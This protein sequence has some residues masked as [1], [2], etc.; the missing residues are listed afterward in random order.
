MLLLWGCENQVH[1]R[2][3]DSD[4]DTVA[5][6]DVSCDGVPCTATPQ[7]G[8]ICDA[9][10]GCCTCTPGRGYCGNS[11]TAAYVC[12]DNG[13][14]YQEILCPPGTVCAERRGSP[15]CEAPADGDDDDDIDPEDA[16]PDD[17][18]MVD[19]DPDMIDGDDEELPW[20]L[21]IPEQDEEVVSEEDLDDTVDNLDEEELPDGDG[22]EPDSEEGESEEE[23]MYQGLLYGSYRLVGMETVPAARVVLYHESSYVAERS[24][25]NTTEYRFEDLPPGNYRVVIEVPGTLEEALERSDNLGVNELQRL[26][27]AL[28]NP[29]GTVEVTVLLEGQDD[30]HGTD[31]SIP[32][33]SFTAVTNASGVA[34]LQRVPR[35]EVS[36]RMEHN[37]YETLLHSGVEVQYNETTY[38]NF[39]LAYASGPDN[40]IRG[41]ARYFNREDASTI[42]ITLSSQDDFLPDQTTHP[43]ANGFWAFDRLEAGS[44][45][46]SVSADWPYQT[47]SIRD[48]EVSHASDIDTGET[49]LR[50]AILRHSGIVENRLRY[51]PDRNYVL[52][53]TN[54]QGDF[55]RLWSVPVEPVFAPAG[56]LAPSAYANSINFVR[57]TTDLLYLYPYDA[58]TRTATI[59]RADMAMPGTSA[60]VLSDV[61]YSY[62][63]DYSATRLIYFRNFAAATA[64]G[65]V[66]VHYLENGDDYLLGENA[67]QGIYLLSGIGGVL[68]TRLTDPV[69]RAAELHFAPLDGSAGT[70]IAPDVYQY[71]MSFHTD[72]HHM[73]FY[74]VS[75]I[76]NYGTLRSVDLEDLDAPLGTM[77]DN[78][79]VQYTRFNPNGDRVFFWRSVAGSFADLYAVDIDPET[80][81]PLEEPRLVVPGFFRYLHRF[82]N[83]EDR[84]VVFADQQTDG[85]FSC[86][87]I[88]TANGSPT[89]LVAGVSNTVLRASA[90]ERWMFVAANY[91]NGYGDIL[92]I[93]RQSGDVWTVATDV[94][95]SL[96]SIDTYNNR[97]I[98]FRDYDAAEQSGTMFVQPLEPGSVEIMVEPMMYFNYRALPGGDKL[99]VLGEY[100]GGIG[101]LRLVDTI[102]WESTILLDIPLSKDGYRLMGQQ[103]L[104]ASDNALYLLPDFDG[105]EALLVAEKTP[106]GLSTLLVDNAR[107]MLWYEVTDPLAPE[108]VSP[109]LYQLYLP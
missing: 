95:V 20:E 28:F 92:R 24:Q 99:L 74:Q 29:V 76:D 45:D 44:Y 6:Q 34:V 94:Y 13:D 23:I 101:T 78:A 50:Y 3:L 10:C 14:C 100:G 40:R 22:P 51:S 55:V 59:N 15:R 107:R 109:G 4:G 69:Q 31:V 82:L 106:Q 93:D 38:L 26:P 52:F 102:T 84:V 41:N 57:D 90:D 72:G 18:D 19:I 86:L 98:Y 71:T 32:G 91:D 7:C 35:G 46:I 103:M 80:L 21:E 53:N 81:E 63:Y 75:D 97:M 67:N 2:M 36:I 37:G 42:L 66:F 5:E 60:S 87:D 12:S 56:I 105:G 16:E 49:V 48:I 30:H 33:T 27:T 85:S 25:F 11:N 77:S 89:D 68:Y 1:I 73:A 39:S 43:D 8:D 65:D 54:R 9:P 79:W 64:S 88:D 83:T 58:A 62:T 108:D 61:Y 96:V 17:I 104:F 47:Q 70:F